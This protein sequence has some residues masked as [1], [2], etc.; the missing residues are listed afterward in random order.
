ME[1]KINW[2]EIA[3]LPRTLG[4]AEETA[5]RERREL[6]VMRA[7]GRLIG[8]FADEADSVT[9]GARPVRLPHAPQ[10][11]LGVV[12]VRGRMR[13]VLDPLALLRGGDLNTTDT[14]PGDPPADGSETPAPRFIVAM[15]GDEQLA[16]AVDRVESIT[17]IFAEAVTPLSHTGGVVRGAVQKERALIAVLDPAEMFSAAMQ[18]TERRRQ[19]S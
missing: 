15:R 6:L 10:A 5:E 4:L 1:D 8:V 9:E 19:R 16:L 13:T 3:I 18:G 7:G 12:S 2:N 14:A 17:E 11:V